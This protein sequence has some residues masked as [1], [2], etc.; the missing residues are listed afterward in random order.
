MAGAGFCPGYTISRSILA[1][2][3]CMTR[4]DRFL[5]V[6]FTCWSFLFDTQDGLYSGMLTKLLFR[7]LPEYYPLR[8]A[9]AHFPFL[10]PNY[11][12]E[13]MQANMQGNVHLDASRTPGSGGRSGGEHG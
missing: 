13:H 2:A 9:Y 3:V 1:D 10:D 11:M 7:T 5:T 4:G 6:E 12:R 8:S